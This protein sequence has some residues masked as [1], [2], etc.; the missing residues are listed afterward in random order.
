[1][2]LCFYSGIEAY[3]VKGEH[4]HDDFKLRE[5][6]AE[7]MTKMNEFTKSRYASTSQ[8]EEDLK[9]KFPPGASLS[10]MPSFSKY[11]KNKYI[12]IFKMICQKQTQHQLPSMMQVFASGLEIQSK[13]D[14][15]TL[16]ESCNEDKANQLGADRYCTSLFGSDKNRERQVFWEKGEVKQACAQIKLSNEI[17]TCA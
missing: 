13:L 15:I 2:Y 8:C 10:M 17:D 1:M 3:N 6:L 14:K 4:I 11:M 5:S 12:N 7:T 9:S 16:Y